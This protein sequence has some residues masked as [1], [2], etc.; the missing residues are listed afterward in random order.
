MRGELGALVGR[1]VR[2]FA[3]DEGKDPAE[4]PLEGEVESGGDGG[5]E[6]GECSLLR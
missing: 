1:G 2:I 5:G 6:N 3:V 4:K